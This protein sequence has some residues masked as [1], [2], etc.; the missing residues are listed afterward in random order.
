MATLRRNR[1]PSE[2]LFLMGVL[3]ERRCARAADAGRR[4]EKRYAR[5]RGRRWK[6]LRRAMDDLA[7]AHASGTERTPARAG[8]R[9]GA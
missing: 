8:D 1:L 6:N 3:S 4:V 2:T 9:S 7:R 5:L